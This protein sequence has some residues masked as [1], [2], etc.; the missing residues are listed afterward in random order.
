MS[1]WIPIAEVNAY[2]LRIKNAIVSGKYRFE[3]RRKNL[4]SLALVGLLPR[5]VKDFILALTHLDYFN[6]PESERNPGFPH[7]DYMFFG[8]EISGKEFIIKIKIEDNG[9]EDFCVC[10]SFHVSTAPITYAYRKHK[11]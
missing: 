5:H 11:S 10:I 2:L 7:G 8:C 1:A 4:E 3:E 6:G 9:G